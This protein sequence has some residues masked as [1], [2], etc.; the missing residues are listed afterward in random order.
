MICCRPPPTP[1]DE[2][3]FDYRHADED[4]RVALADFDLLKKEWDKRVV[5]GQTH[6]FPFVE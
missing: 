5:L 2:S 6:E 3:L 1:P 4:L